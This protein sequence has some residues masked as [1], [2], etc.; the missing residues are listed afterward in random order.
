M[1]ILFVGGNFDLDGGRSS[2]LINKIYESLYKGL[3]NCDSI[4]FFN[5]GSYHQL[6]KII[7][8][9]Q[10]YDVI[11]WFPNVPNKLPKHKTIKSVNPLAIV[12]GSKRNNG[13]YSFVD[14]LNR[15]LLKR[16]NLTVQFSIN[17]EKSVF[18]KENMQHNGLY[19]RNKNGK[20]VFNLFDPLG[21]SWYMGDNVDELASSLLNR[22]GFLLTT[23]RQRTHPSKLKVSV[24]NNIE[25]FNYVHEVAEVFHET[26]QHTSGVTRLLG[27][28][29]FRG[30]NGIIFA[31]QR[32]VDKS[33]ISVNQ[34][35]PAYLQNGTVFYCG[36]NKPSKDTAV[37]LQLYSIFQNVNY[38]VHSHCY[39]D[40]A[41]FTSIPVPCG[42]LEEVDEI[43]KVVE[44]YHCNDTTLK[45]YAV[46]LIG[47]GCIVMADTVES[48]KNT[49]YITRQLPERIK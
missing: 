42:A 48:L 13:E 36:Q 45:K 5:G 38:I 43:R 22:L 14:V 40:G 9:A 15:T 20:Y 34:F 21:T 44:L 25:F 29:S 1:K 18:N 16:D 3:C 11:L 30:E 12:V 32:D 46:N 4:D 26:V 23:H 39:V 27:N 10:K 19:Q 41:H 7:D 37:Q 49:K 47:H 28:A 2:G 8:S 31:S 33:V 17:Y 6:E 24:P 35:V